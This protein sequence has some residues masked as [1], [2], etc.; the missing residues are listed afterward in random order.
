[1]GKN[2]GQHL[3][4][5]I[6]IT[7]VIRV[8]GFIGRPESA[9]KSPG[10]QFFFVNNRFMKNAYLH[11][12]VMKS[13]EKLLPPETI[14]PYFIFLETDPNNSD[15]IGDGLPDGWK[16]RYGLDPLDGAA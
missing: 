16:V 4:D 13:Y 2:L 3:L 8:N 6:T 5:I 14:P 15:T 9:K 12:A 7:T 11:K 10:E 1:M